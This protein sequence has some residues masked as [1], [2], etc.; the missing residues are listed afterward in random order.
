MTL[1]RLKIIAVIAMTID[2]IGA[3]LFPQAMWL[4]IIGRLALPI[5]AWAIAN[6]YHY[7]HS[8]MTYLM[9][10]LL[11]AS[12]SQIPF[13]FIYNG[14]F[15]TPYLLN[16]FF[17]LAYGLGVIM[18]YERYKETTVG[19]LLVLF[20]LGIG[21]LL[22]LEYGLYGVVT[23]FLFHLTYKQPK[24]MIVTQILWTLF[25]IALRGQYGV[26]FDFVG[27]TLYA[28]SVYQVYMIGSLPLIYAYT[29]KPG[30]TKY[31]WWF[32]WFYPVH[33]ILLFAVYR[34]L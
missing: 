15:N 1:F 24:D 25:A 23:V 9:R 8:R 30:Y 10:L 26:T 33:L 12:I 13:W 22:P 28:A 14:I 4:R 20:T 31:K 3:F 17:T 11:F 5:F 16:I 21:S 18:V 34:F 6:G 19:W 32:Y 27:Y 29:G 2:H 7:T